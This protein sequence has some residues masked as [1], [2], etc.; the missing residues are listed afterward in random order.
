MGR[1]EIPMR[2]VAAARPGYR[3]YIKGVL[4]RFFLSYDKP[5]YNSAAY[6]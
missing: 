3:F 6:S 5:T 2:A 4:R 1:G